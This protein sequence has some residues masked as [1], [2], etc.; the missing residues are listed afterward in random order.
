MVVMA[1]DRFGPLEAVDLFRKDV[2]GAESNVAIGLARL[3]HEVAWIGRLG[4]DPFG[5]FI[6]NRLRGEGVDV[7]AVRFDPD[8]PTGL[9]VKEM[10]G[11][12]TSVYYYRAGS[13][14]GGLRAEECRLDR[15]SGARYLFVTGI[16]PAL[17]GSCRDAVFGAVDEARRLG[18]TVAF[19]PNLRLKLWPLAE[20]RAVMDALADRADLVLPGLEEGRALTG[21]SAPEEIADYYSGKGAELVAVKMGVDGAY[22]RSG[23]A[24]GR[25]PAFPVP[26]VDEVGAGDAFDAGLLSGLLDG[27][28]LSAAVERGCAL[29]AMA[30]TAVGDS[31]ALPYRAG[32]ERFLSANS[33]MGR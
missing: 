14:A 23:A 1:P 18:M 21:R 31:A 22:Y 28:S 10:A 17:S 26:T 7:S 11:W 15:F 3:G 5:R 4:Q 12:R 32:L 20:A 27:L 19:D 8:R 13:A 29:G 16:T 9:Y 33:E 24:E 2:A 30:V 25:V 6:Y